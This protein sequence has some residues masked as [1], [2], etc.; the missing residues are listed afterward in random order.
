LTRR[1]PYECTGRSVGLCQR[2]AQ[3]GR[4]GVLGS[5]QVLADADVDGAVAAGGPDEPLDRPAGAVLAP[6]ANDVYPRANLQVERPI[7]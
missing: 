7:G 4:Q 5:E 1:R 2:V 6:S 3:F